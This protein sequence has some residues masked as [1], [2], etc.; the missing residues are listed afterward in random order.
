LQVF[1][2]NL[3]SEPDRRA[4]VEWQLKE[5]GLRG[6]RVAAVTPADIADHL[7]AKYCPGFGPH[8]LSPPELACTFS[9]I[10][11]LRLIAE[12]NETFGVVLEDDAILSRSLT[13]FLKAFEGA[14][15]SVDV[16]KLDSQNDGCRVVGR[17]D[18]RI[19]GVFLREI[20]SPRASAAA[21]LVSR[22]AAQEIADHRD[23]LRA[24]ID[25]T[26]YHPISRV[27]RGL[28]VRHAEPGLAAHPQLK[29][30]SSSL[31]PGRREVR[32]GT[33]G[34]R[35]LVANL[36]ARFKQERMDLRKSIIK[37]FGPGT[38]DRKIAIK[39]DLVLTL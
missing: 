5:L 33:K 32:L 21:Y 20:V 28:R 16:L 11:T 31:A 12:G 14:A 2:I 25:L 36:R 7:L 30:E 9:H 26:L 8:L 3:D 6:T 38:D 34:P 17:Q 13:M 19:D 15:P 18:D 22:K 39:G 35:R 24:P 1:Y 29:F 27:V 23:I 37:R 10:K 4:R